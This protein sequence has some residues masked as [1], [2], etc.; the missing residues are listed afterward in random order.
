M[1][2]RSSTAVLSPAELSALRRVADGRSNDVKAEHLDVL[3]AM[4]LLVLDQN[5]RASLSIDGQQRLRAALAAQ[6]PR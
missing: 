5:G 4:G 6:A 1:T 2:N 3:F